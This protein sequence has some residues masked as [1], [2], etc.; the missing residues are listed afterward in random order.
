VPILFGISHYCKVRFEKRNIVGIHNT[1]IA[2]IDRNAHE[3]ERVGGKFK[4]VETD[5]QSYF[6]HF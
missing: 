4:T 2:K 1:H 5:I 6:N 3:K